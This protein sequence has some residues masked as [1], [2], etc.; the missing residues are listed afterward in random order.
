MADR[1]QWNFLERASFG[2]RRTI[3]TI[4]AHMRDEAADTVIPGGQH[5]PLGVRGGTVRPPLGETPTGEAGQPVPGQ[6]V[7]G[8]PVR[9]ARRG[10]GGPPLADARRLLALILALS[11]VSYAAVA[12]DVVQGGGLAELDQSTSEWVA[13]SM[14]GWAEWIARVLSVVGGF[15]GVTLVVVPAVAWLLRRGERAAGVLLAVVAIGAQLL[16]TASKNGYDRPRPTTGSPIDLPSSW[17]FPSGHALTGIAVFGL[18]GL[19]LAAHLRPPTK[20]AMAIAAGVT[21]AALI[22]ASRV[23]LNVHFVSDVLAGA[24]LGLGWLASCLLVA[25]LVERARRR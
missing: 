19:L 18:L 14:P 17:S 5:A 1:Y 24:A 15:I 10:S 8:Q 13:R 12:A 4:S 25:G 11:L 21:L 16:T 7:R 9:G 22:G 6:P 3:D 2:G 20:R 23:V